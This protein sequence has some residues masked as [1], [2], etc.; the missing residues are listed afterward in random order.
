MRRRRGG[1][2]SAL[3]Y[4][5]DARYATVI[6]SGHVRPAAGRSSGIV[7]MNHGKPRDRRMKIRNTPSLERSDVGGPQ[8]G[9]AERNTCHPRSD[10]LPSLEQHVLGN[11]IVEELAL[12]RIHFLRVTLVE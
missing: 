12:K 8:V 6:A 1:S 10:T 9:S 2:T 4:R 3:V 7:P 11:V 5:T